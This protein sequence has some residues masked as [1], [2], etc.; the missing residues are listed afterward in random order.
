[1]GTNI[2]SNPATVFSIREVKEMP[3]G[4]ITGAVVGKVIRRPSKVNKS[5][6][7]VIEDRER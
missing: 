4:K 3:T 2:I 7:I 5:M 6:N 1:M